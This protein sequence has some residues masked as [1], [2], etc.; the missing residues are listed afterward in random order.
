MDGES[1]G[2]GLALTFLDMEK[3]SSFILH[4]FTTIWAKGER[5]YSQSWLQL[6][7]LFTM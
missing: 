3:T 4:P 7:P 1:Q 2:L 5:S 6:G